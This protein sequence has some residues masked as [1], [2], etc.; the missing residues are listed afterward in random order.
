MCAGQQ[1]RHNTKSM[2][3]GPASRDRRYEFHC[4]THLV[5]ARAVIAFRLQ[6]LHQQRETQI[7]LETPDDAKL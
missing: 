2:A 3:D 4:E 5:F 7:L 1:Q 6:S